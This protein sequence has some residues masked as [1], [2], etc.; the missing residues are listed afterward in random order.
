M[1]EKKV[2]SR[3]AKAIYGLAKE[4]NLQDTVL[5]DFTLILKT[6]ADSKELG[7]L[8]ESP[9]VSSKKKYDIF[10]EVFED[11]ISD[12]TYRFIKLLTEKSRE[13]LLDDIAYQYELI[14]NEANN[15]LP[16]IIYSAV[17]LD[18]DA[19]SQIISKLT[20]WTKKTILSEFKVD[21]SIKGGL[22]I[23]ISDWVFDASVQNQ[24]DKLRIALAG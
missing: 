12:T 10:K 1:H 21:P 7:N 2:S 14:Y 3:Y 18:E 8:V 15:R 16:V 6:I 19:K 4:S 24:L 23:K 17:E 22:K 13:N 5:S 11:S 9:V 20:E